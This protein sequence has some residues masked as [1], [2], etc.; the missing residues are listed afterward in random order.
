MKHMDNARGLRR[1]WVMVMTWTLAIGGLAGA[2]ARGADSMVPRVTFDKQ[3]VTVD[4]KDLLIFSGAFHYFRCPK[5]LWRDRFRKLKE[6]GFNTV[7]TYAAWNWHEPNPPANVDDFSKMNTTDISDWLA[8]A[9]DEFGMYVYFRPGPYICAEW[10]GGGYPQWLP[11]LR[12][13]DFKAPLWLRSDEPTYLAW[14]K[15]WFTAA[16]KAAKPFLITNR[17][18]GK[19]GIILWQIEN[20]YNY[21]NVP[22]PAKVK[23]L[24]FLARLSRE[25]GIDVPLTTCVTHDPQ[26]LKNE[27]LKQNV[28]ET[29]NTYPKFSVQ[30]EAKDLVVLDTY[31][32]D[33]FRMVTELQGG[34]F[35]QVGGKLSEE[36]G[37]DATHINHVTQFAW[38]NGFTATN[39]YM[40]FGGTNFGDWGASSITTTYDYDAPV[41]EGGGVTQRYMAVKALGVF[42]AEHGQQLVR[43]VGEKIEVKDKKDDDVTVTL[44]RAVDGSR[45]LFV[46]TEVRD[47]NRKGPVTIAT[48]GAD[49]VEI[50]ANYDLGPFGAKI[51]YLPP[52]ATNAA[53]GQW[54]PKTVDGPKRPELNELPAVVKITE[55]R[56]KADPGPSDWRPLKEGQSAE[57]AGIFNRGFLFYRATVPSLP[58]TGRNAFSYRT[59]GRDWAGFMMNN[60]RLSADP[61]T[62]G[63]MLDGSNTGKLITGIYE[64]YGRANG[65]AE[66]EKPSG[67]FDLKIAPI[68][69]TPRSI[70]GWR[71]KVS[72]ERRHDAE[73]DPKTDDS[74]WTAADVTQDEG[75]LEPEQTAVFRAWVEMSGADL[76]SGKALVLGRVD[77]DGTVYINGKKIG[78]SHDW[79]PAQRFDVGGALKPGKNLIAVVVVNHDGVGGLARGTSIE[80]TG[81]SIAMNWEISDQPAGVAGKWWENSVDDSSW[82]ATKIDESAVTPE[83]SAPQLTWYRM[84]FELLEPKKNLWA[85]YR[86]H[87]DAV[88]NGF[89]YLNGR[90]LGRWWQVGP[91]REYY[92]PET[93]LN[94][95]PGK[96]NVV[97][98]SLRATDEVGVKRAEVGVF[99]NQA[100]AR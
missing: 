42:L 78:E 93:W 67:V 74:S 19:T 99:E 11:A 23:Q 44:R 7:E 9:T 63:Y 48:S 21:S 91:Q 24:E 62:G 60:V 46:R 43:A 73:V 22:V 5:E 69:E 37:F 80:S 95:G 25:L 84:K 97:T 39:Y 30:N 27:Y 50:T 57:A 75:E 15:H 89:V 36:Q 56:T 82:T 76:K 1:H 16:A 79:E 96:A 68:D 35:S 32:P 53:A 47:S 98:I 18:T 12:P 38:E 3:C 17:P 88:G 77:E 51:L 13:V 8:M 49:A 94:F 2:A 4:G 87:L 64:N 72:K 92:L 81:P 71:M 10:D 85:P 70:S 40:A 29:R 90:A 83:D 14:C 58:A 61:T 31:Q 33:K 28:I 86:L 41:R 65:G 100:E 6:A 66:M 52:G 55:M 59:R 26:F 20:E 34:W 54:Y 45:F